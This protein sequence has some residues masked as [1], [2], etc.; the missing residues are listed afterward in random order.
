MKSIE[1]R[2]KHNCIIIEKG[3]GK[4]IEKGSHLFCGV[5][6]HSL[7]YTSRIIKMPSCSTILKNNIMD[8]TFEFGVLGSLYHKT[9]GHTMFSMQND[10]WKFIQIGDY[11]TC[12]LIKEI[13][14]NV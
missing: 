7:G 1:I 12:E 6:G 3:I 2:N 9:C 14:E 13:E 5:C 4:L 8:R 10:G 11:F